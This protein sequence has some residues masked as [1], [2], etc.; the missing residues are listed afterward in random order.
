M[1]SP[2]DIQARLRQRP[3]TPMRV[4][5]STGESYDIF[6][7]DMAIVGRRF[8][9]VGMPSAEN[10]E[11]AEQV[12]RVANVHIAELRDLIVPTPPAGGNGK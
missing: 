2:D 5:L 10:P 6:H 4:I 7:P 12:T 1:F 9:M 11:Q 3:F 8:L